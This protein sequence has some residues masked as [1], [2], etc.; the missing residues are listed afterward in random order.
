MFFII[1]FT[2]T[3]IASFLILSIPIQNKQLFSHIHHAFEPFTNEFVRV[4]K[5]N[6]QRALKETSEIG[7]RAFSNTKPTDSA[8][9]DKVSETQSS[10]KK[11]EIFHD[12]YTDEEKDLLLRV[13]ESAR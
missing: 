6:G 7:K 11:A 9:K 8:V 3:F 5:R 12:D 1:K 2:L 13:L 10:F 4:V